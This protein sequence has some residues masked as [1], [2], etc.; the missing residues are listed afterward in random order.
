[1]AKTIAGDLSGLQNRMQAL[2]ENMGGKLE[3]S[4]PPMAKVLLVLEKLG[5]S[6]T[7]IRGTVNSL[8]RMVVEMQENTKTEL[9]GLRADYT[10]LKVQLDTFAVK[11]IE[12]PALDTLESKLGSV[13]EEQK[14]V[15]HTLARISKTMESQMSLLK[16][17]TST[18]TTSGPAVDMAQVMEG[19]DAKIKSYAEVTK[20]TQAE[21]FQVHETEREARAAR[22]LNL[23]IVGL[24]EEEAYVLFFSEDEVTHVLNKMESGK[25]R[26]LQGLVVELLKWGSTAVS[27]ALTQLII[28]GKLIDTRLSSWCDTHNKRAPVQG[29]FRRAY[30][31]LDHC[32][33]LRVLSEKAKR[34]GHSLF[35]LFVD[36]KKAFDTVQR[37]RLLLRLS[38][39]GVP[40]DLIHSVVKLYQ[41]VLI[42]IALEDEG[43]TNNLGVIQGCPASPTLFS[44]IIDEL[45]WRMQEPMGRVNL[46]TSAVPMLIFADDVALFAGD[47]SQ[48]EN[49]IRN[50]EGFCAD[51]GMTVN[52]DKTRWICVG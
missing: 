21:L 18:A 23:R 2:K 51:S 37:D 4:I 11:A 50:L 20:T 38:Q 9:A 48:M 14:Q 39:I 13:Q 32:L 25:A 22:S 42:K 8:N 26:D 47:T 6:I 49:H 43:V 15:V 7:D 1:M 44:L 40:G 17:K 31:T 34:A 45:F 3:E 36:L 5:E 33:V 10:Q 19:I 52:L 28:R 16:E 29:G 12:T 41:K 46:G 30:C 27:T 35:I 24:E